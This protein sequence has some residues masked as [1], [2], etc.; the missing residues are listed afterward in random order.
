M[1]VFWSL[2]SLIIVFSLS[3]NTVMGQ[4]PDWRQYTNG[5]YIDCQAVDGDIIWAGTSVGLVKINSITHETE[6]YNAAN[7]PV[8]YNRVIDIAVDDSGVKWFASSYRVASGGDS[9]VTALIRYDDSDWTVFTPENSPIT[10][11]DRITCLDVDENGNLWIGTERKSVFT[12]DGT[13]WEVFDS[14]YSVILNGVINSIRTQPGNVV[15]VASDQGLTRYD[16]TNWT[17]FSQF[18]GFSSIALDSESLLWLIGGR[19]G[20]SILYSFDG[21]S[22]TSYAD[23]YG[24][25]RTIYCL[26]VDDDNVKWMGMMHNGI[27]SFD[28]ENYE[29]YNTSNSGLTDNQIFSITCS[30]NGKIL[31]GTK[32]CGVVS[33]DGD[34]EWESYNTSICPSLP[35]NGMNAIEYH[36]GWIWAGTADGLAKFNNN[37]E[38]VIFPDSILANGANSV[39]TIAFEDDNITWIGS[40]SSWDGSGGLTKMEGLNITHFTSSNSPLPSENVFCIIVDTD[41]SKWITTNNGVAYFDDTN[42]TIYNT[43]NSA[44]PSN[45]VYT[46]AIDAHGTVWFG[47]YMGLASFDGTNWQEYSDIVHEISIECLAFAPDGDLWIG[48]S[49]GG[50]GCFNGDSLIVYHPG[51]SDIPDPRIKAIEFYNDTMWVGTL[52]GLASFSDN[53]WYT[54]HMNNSG[55][56]D[57]NITCLTIDPTNSLKY[58]GHWQGG[59]SVYGESVNDIPSEPS[60]VPSRIALS[61][62]YPNPFNA[63]TRISF[64]LPRQCDVDF[65][66]YNIMGQLVYSKTIEAMPVGQHSLIW[67]GRNNNGNNISSGVYLYKI[68]TPQ[69]SETRK[70]I[71]LK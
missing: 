53:N 12:Y 37:D 40:T 60:P 20:N 9:L 29:V 27:G 69:I 64:D 7:S 21:S 34:T 18:G 68:T 32:S 58:M 57:E 13:D 23:G 54:Y 24:I 3:P 52:K 46:T 65:D 59:I 42:W 49:S 22:F 6:F 11:G 50:L 44:L 66:V 55:L 30:A 2:L 48:A 10:Y 26:D 33:F 45:E 16:G 51:N 4:Y 25:P 5:D 31:I 41:G 35:S 71:L 1:K 19:G 70:M 62:N 56:S 67:N 14:S 47:T 39:K 61:Q 36:N 17:N 63:T 38:W 8:K 43:E 28:G 15:W